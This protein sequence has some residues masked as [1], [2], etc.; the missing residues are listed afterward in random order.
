MFLALP[1]ALQLLLAPLL[2]VSDL[3]HRQEQKV[4]I[5]RPPSRTFTLRHE[6]AIA[7]DSRVLFADIPQSFLSEQHTINTRTIQ[8]YRPSSLR[9]FSSARSSYSNGV[10]D[11]NLWIQKTTPAPD[12]GER[13]TLLSLAKMTNNAYFAPSDKEWYALDP[14]WGN[15]VSARVESPLAFPLR[16]F[17]LELPVRLG[18]RC[19]RIQR[20]HICIG[21]QLDRR[22]LHKGYFRWMDCW[23]RRAYG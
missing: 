16:R 3:G 17:L 14:S 23:R 11:S 20:L 5:D 9:A 15:D 12:V 19:G 7:N 21:R 4:L 22:P 10:T 1:S 2:L 13:E 8:T 18:A 6:H